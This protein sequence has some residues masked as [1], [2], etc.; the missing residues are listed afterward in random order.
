MRQAV[1][2]APGVVK[3]VEAEVPEPNSNQVQINVKRIG[4]CGSDVHVWHGAHPFTSYPVIQG[5]EYCGIVSKI[6]ADVTDICVGQLVTALPQEVC[7]ECVPCRRGNWHLCDNLKVR[8]F[9]A[10]GCAQDYFVTEIDKVIVLPESFTLEQG[11]FIEPLAVASHSTSRAGL[12]RGANIAVIGAGTI[13]NFV[14]QMAQAKGAKVLIGDVS[15]TRLG[16]ARA[17]GLEHVFNPEVDHLSKAA[18]S[19]FG[20][21]GLDI[22]FDCAGAQLSL[23]AAISSVNKGGT[24]LIVAVFDQ[25]PQVDMAVVC[26]SEL[27]IIGTMMYHH[28]DYQQAVESLVAGD[29][30][31]TP[32]ESEHFTLEEFQSAYEFIDQRASESMKVFIDLD[33]QL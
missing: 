33:S 11:A 3:I 12:L 16:V 25:K 7:G 1:M 32:L 22:V 23:D 2:T 13:G 8:G 14:G 31:T 18:D 27:N 24:V 28:N 17:C 29:V 26:E 21:E 10:P 4:I 20:S 5:H 15:E 6:G 30:K 9:Q 19:V